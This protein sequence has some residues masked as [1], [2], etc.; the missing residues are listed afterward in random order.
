VRS[1]QTVAKYE[2][3][4]QLPSE[5]VGPRQYRTRTDV[6][7]EDWS[8]LETIAA[9]QQRYPAFKALLKPPPSAEAP[10]AEAP[11]AEALTFRRERSRLYPGD[12][13]FHTA[14][15]LPADAATW[16]AWVKF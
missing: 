1:R 4:G 6:F 7:A 5:R 15:W 3:L 13:R 2:Q 14:L 12:P 11:S 16:R 10:S 8:M 9:T